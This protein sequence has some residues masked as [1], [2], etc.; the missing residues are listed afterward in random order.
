MSERGQT[1]D[2]PTSPDPDRSIWRV[3]DWLVRAS[4]WTWRLLVLG[5]GSLVVLLVLGRLRVV[6][7]PVLIALLLTALASPVTSWLTSHRVPRIVAAWVTLLLVVGV[8]VGVVWVTAVGLVDQL[9]DDAQ[10]D[11]VR[12]EVRRWLRE[13]PLDLT[14]Q[15]V[16]QLER[17][18]RDVVVDGATT[19][20]AGR[21]R[22]V[23][24]IVGGVFL[25]VVL[26]FF[27]TKDGPSMWGW[28]TGHVRQHRRAEV[29]EAGRAAFAALTGYMRGVAITGFIDAVAIGIALW[30][31]GV[32]LVVPL[33]LLTFFGAFF[34]IVGATVAG[35]LATVVALVVNGPVDAV[36]VAGVTLA[37]QQL[38][39]DVIMPLVM[40]RRV[41]L[42]PAV[43][44][45]ALGIGGALAGIIGAFVAVP[46]AAM[47]AAAGGVVRQSD[48]SADPD[49]D[50]D[51]DGDG[52]EP[53]TEPHDVAAGG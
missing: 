28:L 21:V 39:G 48:R 34:P 22:L 40:R 50:R 25:T 4:G 53:E 52:G 3:P 20:D 36:L 44:L 8:V 9:L 35:A 27:F 42:H 11:D 17:R 29:D 2:V 18:A 5:A 26:F 31:I 14:S 32:P 13:G 10:W 49:P 6:L 43:I 46:F 23:T 41:S 33:A 12:T 37:I 30:I 24:E 7:V 45:V 47:L 16:A 38:E 51:R 1:S 15:E 19:I